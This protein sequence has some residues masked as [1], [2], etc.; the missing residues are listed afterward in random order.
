MP[1]NSTIHKTWFSRSAR[2]SCKCITIWVISLTSTAHKYLLA[3]TEDPSRFSIFANCNFKF[4]DKFRI[5]RYVTTS[6]MVRSKVRS[7][8]IKCLCQKSD[9]RNQSDKCANC[10]ILL[11]AKIRTSGKDARRHPWLRESMASQLDKLFAH[12]TLR[13]GSSLHRLDICG[14][15]SAQPSLR[16][17]ELPGT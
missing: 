7:V 17:D 5:L 14:A 12:R 15:L 13:Y 6:K 2:P 4:D 10:S 11:L 16:G 9:K 3:Y 1:S 8:C